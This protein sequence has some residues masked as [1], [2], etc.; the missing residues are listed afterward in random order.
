MEEFLKQINLKNGKA[1]WSLLLLLILIWL[2]VEYG[3]ATL[4]DYFYLNEKVFRG[5]IWRLF[6]PSIIH[7][8]F[9]HVI[10]SCC[11]L[12]FLGY[13]IEYYFGTGRFI[14]L[15]ALLMLFSNCTEFLLGSRSIGF[16]S[17]SVGIG[18]F[19]WRRE[20]SFKE[21]F[22]FPLL[23]K[24]ILFAGNFTVWMIA[25]AESHHLFPFIT[26][27]ADRISEWLS[28]PNVTEI[29]H[30]AHFIGGVFGFLLGGFSRFRYRITLSD[31]ASKEKSSLSSN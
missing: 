12:I 29:S 16:S 26:H 18:A 2:C 3:P 8:N 31:L 7:S 9:G 14:L 1:T 17:I 15:I 10:K 24:L 23:E 22:Y 6:T 4:P 5:E 20:F 21:K 19:L 28:R 30:I 27:L 25:L 11:W 13:Q